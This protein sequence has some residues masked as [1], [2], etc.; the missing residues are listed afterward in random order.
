MRIQLVCWVK[1][2]EKIEKKYMECEMSDLTLILDS[3]E[4]LEDYEFEILQK[5][6]NTH[7]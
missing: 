5:E 6:Q 3:I 7:E 2:N 1:T 4:G